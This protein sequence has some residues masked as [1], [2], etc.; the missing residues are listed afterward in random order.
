MNYVSIKTEDLSNG[1]GLRLSLF[2]SGC[3]HGCKG[4][5]NRAAWNPNAG[6]EVTPEVVANLM[7]ALA[8]HD[9][10]SILG[11]DPLFHRNVE[12]LTQILKQAKTLYPEKDVWLWTGYLYEDVKHLEIM[13]YVDVLIDGKYE[14]NNP[15]TQPW[16]G[17]DNQRLIH[18]KEIT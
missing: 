15:T 9:G 3:S 11:G 18:I 13:R 10:L 12:P 2:V 17:S 6:F 1:E 5:F 16:R 7:A 14:K 8:R 4:C